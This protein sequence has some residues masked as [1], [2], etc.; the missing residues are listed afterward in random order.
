[1]GSPRGNV[2]EAVATFHGVLEILR[3]V[4]VR[5]TPAGSL[6]CGNVRFTFLGP[7]IEQTRVGSWFCDLGPVLNPFIQ[8][9]F[10]KRS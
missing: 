2:E 1:M 3:L 10:Q 8:F 9:S 6:P 5:R 7:E 4:W